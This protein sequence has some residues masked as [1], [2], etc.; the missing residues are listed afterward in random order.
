LGLE[1]RQ[2]I[3][4][5]LPGETLDRLK[6]RHFSTHSTE[7]EN[8]DGRDHDCQTTQVTSTQAAMVKRLQCRHGVRRLSFTSGVDTGLT[9]FA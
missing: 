5:G 9:L 1:F 7:S 6:R 3:F 8:D 2:A 4:P